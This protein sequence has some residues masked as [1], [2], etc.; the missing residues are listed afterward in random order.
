[1]TDRLGPDLGS[2]ST[3]ARRNDYPDKEELTMDDDEI[4][5][6]DGCWAC[7]EQIRH[8]ERAA[9]ECVHRRS[10]GRLRSCCADELSAHVQMLQAVFQSRRGH[11][12]ADPRELTGHLGAP[13]GPDAA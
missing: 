3:G 6:A 10:D 11:G 4:L 1:M 9:G 13:I 2:G 5:L 8:D 12:P 7:H